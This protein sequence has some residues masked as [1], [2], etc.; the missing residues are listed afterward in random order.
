M[1]PWLQLDTNR[2][3]NVAHS[4]VPLGLTLG[5]ILKF[6]LIFSSYLR[7]KYVIVKIA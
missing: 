7:L 1:D 6:T 2:K 3:W 5:D 4:A